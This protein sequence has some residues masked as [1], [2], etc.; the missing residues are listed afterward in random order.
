MQQANTAE[1]G[2][3]STSSEPTRTDGWKELISK[4]DYWAIWVGFALIAIGM[5]IF[6]PRPPEGMR[7]KITRANA[8]M[9]A[10]AKAAPF[11]TVAWYQ[12]HDAKGRVKATGEAYAHRVKRWL[13]KPHS[14][15]NNPVDAFLLSSDKA[16]A[17]NAPLAKAYQAAHQETQALLTQAQAAETAARGAQFKDAK[18]NRAAAAG[19]GKWS[20]AQ[21]AASKA[22]RKAKVAPHC[23]AGYLAGLCAM[24]AVVFCIG[25][26]FM[27]E[28]PLRFVAGFPFVFVIAVLSYMM[29]GQ[30]TMKA[31]GIGYAAW[32]IVFG[33]LISNTVGT[34]AWARPAARTEYYIKTGLVLLG[35][36]VLFGKILAIGAPGLVVAWVVTPT[37]IVASY[38]FGVH[39]LK[40]MSKTLNITIAAAVSVCGVSAAIATAAACRA[41]KEELTLAV[42]MSL[43]FTAIMMILMPSLIKAMGMDHVIGGAWIGGTVDSTGAV[44]AAGEFL[45]DRAL[46]VAATVKMIQNILIGV[47]AFCVAVYWCARVDTEACGHVRAS[48]IWFRFPK[49]VL[50]FVAASILCSL[51][52]QRMGSDVGHAM[53]DYG[54]L[55]GFTK[56]LRGWFFCLAFVSIG[57][58]TNFREL[59]R[60]F[61]HGQPLVLYI[62]GQSLNLV[63][64]L[65]MV[66]LMF[67]VVFPNIADKV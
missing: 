15:H 63:L 17:I 56:V 20:D 31:Y 1:E 51:V 14:W 61:S 8:A 11:K 26:K 39:V 3:A 25:V 34:P 45:S 57:L 49:F 7:E 47:V 28:S 64:T 16:A 33:L 32:G 59:R 37:V 40:G 62:V 10:E 48:E 42:G 21:S 54:V 38:L 5:A 30:A 58:A 4:E 24:L 9:E 23:Q 19:I 36:E 18:L 13:S 50:G 60:H 22:K 41:K 53:M 55:R 66:Y 27:G 29:A 67:R 35:A 43:V 65:A 2:A 44:A 6:L 52:Y 46:Y 12:A